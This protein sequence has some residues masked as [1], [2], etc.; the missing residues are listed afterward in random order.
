MNIIGMAGQHQQ[1]NVVIIGNVYAKQKY[2][3]DAQPIHIVKVVPIQH[4]HHVQ[5]IDQLQIL[6]RDKHPLMHV[7]L[8]EQ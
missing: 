3:S 6:K 1:Q 4:V 2:V 8:C 7:Y 5:K